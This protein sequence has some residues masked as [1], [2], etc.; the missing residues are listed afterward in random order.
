MTD[1]PARVSQ[2]ARANTTSTAPPA[3]CKD[4]VDLFRDTGIGKEGYS[5]IGQGRI[6]EI[7]S[8][9]S[10]D[11]RGRFLRRLRASSNTR[12]RKEEC[13]KRLCDHTRDNLSRVEDILAE[14]DRAQLEPLEEAERSGAAT[15]WHL[16]DE[17]TRAGTVRAFV[18]AHA[19][20]PRSA[21]QRLERAARRLG[22]G[23]CPR[24]KSAPDESER[25]SARSADAGARRTL[26][27]AVTAAAH[28][29]V[30]ELTREVGSS[31]KASV[32]RRRARTST[33]WRS[34]RACACTSG[35]GREARPERPRLMRIIAII[36]RDALANRTNDHRADASRRQPDG[37]KRCKPRRKKPERPKKS[38]KPI[39]S[40][41]HRRDEPPERRAHQ[42]G[43]AFH[44]A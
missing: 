21:L 18:H 41:H 23:H 10:E 27:N 32:R 1:H 4:I 2:A 35:R 14:L 26:E 38:W 11:R 15:I 7:L 44:H 3:A 28:D 19:T 43:A 34:R 25:G 12:T 24:G 37:K 42:R 40:S 36:E 20:A 29:A 16:R 39:S 8:Q 17:L 31:A 33:A 22:R 6:D 30:L 13:E 5:I 9:K